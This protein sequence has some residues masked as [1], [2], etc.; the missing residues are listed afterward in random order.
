M[1]LIEISKIVVPP[2]R[3]RTDFN[4]KRLEEL[5]DSI[6][7][8][9]L[10][11]PVVLRDDGATLVCGE[12]RLRVLGKRDTAYRHNGASVNPGWIPYV[13]LSELPPDL[14]E[15][16]ELDENIKRVDLTWQ[17]RARAIAKLDALRKRQNPEHSASDTA[18]EIQGKANVTGNEITEVTNAVLLAKFLDDPIIGACKDEKEARKA[19]REELDR[20][21]R[22]RRVQSLDLT[23]VRHKLTV[24]D[25]YTSGIPAGLFDCIVTDPPYGIDIDKKD[26]FDNDKHEYDDSDAAFQ[27]VCE[28]LP[29]LAARAA[30]PN[31]HIYVFCDIRR[32]QELFVAFELGGWTCWPRPLIWDK[33]N[34]GSFGNIEYGFR[35]CYDAILFARR[36]DRKVTAGYRDVIPITQPTNLPH[37]AGKP[38]DLFV[39]LLRRSCLPGDVVAD[40]YCGHGPIFSAAEQLRLVAYGWEKNP[41]YAEMAQ[42]T[43]SKISGKR[44][45]AA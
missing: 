23:T 15:E 38:T 40:F 2:E 35:A 37:P 33:G 11:H 27:E 10:F 30:K 3:Q 7:R 5:N 44:S 36:G 34:T 41:K 14:L 9:G 1:Q 6:S 8:L 31:A 13:R 28:K 26:T 29:E 25:V 32:W 19:I 20:K 22:Q 42:D 39:E 18:R 16:A 21:E 17:E 4:A 43:L 45:D 12:R 24:G